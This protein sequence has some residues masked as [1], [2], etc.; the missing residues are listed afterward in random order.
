MGLGHHKSFDL[1]RF[2]KSVLTVI[3]SLDFLSSPEM[4]MS[5][6][7]STSEQTPSHTA[8]LSGSD[9]VH[10]T[11]VRTACAHTHG[12][13]LLDLTWKQLH[14]TK[15]LSNGALQACSNPLSSDG[16]APLSCLLT[17]HPDSRASC[18]RAT[19]KTFAS[20]FSCHKQVFKKKETK[21]I[22]K[23]SMTFNF[24]RNRNPSPLGESSVCDLSLRLHFRSSWG[25]FTL[26]ELSYRAVFSNWH[27]LAHIG[28]N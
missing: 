26:S 13:K 3:L 9:N 6:Y 10:V 21:K 20:V 19:S 22:E 16:E 11:C 8:E 28:S 2:S 15:W 12:N 27:I 23:H 7:E 24:T 4:E 14:C 18:L 25:I 5:G 17:T 1:M